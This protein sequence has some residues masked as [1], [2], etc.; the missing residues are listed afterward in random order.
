MNRQKIAVRMLAAVLLLNL[1][2]G[3][4]IQPPPVHA[5]GQPDLIITD[6]WVEDAGI[7][8]QIRNVGDAAAPG[9]HVSALYI[10]NIH[11]AAETVMNSLAPGERRNLCF[12]S[13][14][15]QCSPPQ[16]LVR[17]RA[18]ALDDYIAESD[19]TNNSIE[20]T[21][22]CD[23]TPP[24]ITS[25]PTVSSITQNSATVSWTTDESS[26]SMV[27]YDQNAGSYENKRGILTFVTDHQVDLTDLNPATVYHYIVQSTDSSGNKVTSAEGFFRTTVPPDSVA[28]DVSEFAMASRHLPMEF[29]VDALDDVGVHKV[30]FSFDGIAAM[31]DYDAPYQLYLD[32]VQL[33]LS[34]PEFF[35]EHVIEATAFD[36]GGMLRT[37]VISPALAA[38][39]S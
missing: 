11:R 20:E 29:T 7:C 35:G 10:D 12:P 34:R 31:M 39:C 37:I 24:K 32:P 13:W 38:V 17:V 27:Q 6:V 9:G 5:Q 22:L 30:E 25:G 28:P 19:E 18:D 15:W 21:W 16:D 2:V 14:Q 8:Y 4:G 3:A 36:L 33:G 1:A 23:T 26:N